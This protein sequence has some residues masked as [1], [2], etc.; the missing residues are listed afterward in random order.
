MGEKLHSLSWEKALVVCS[1]ALILSTWDFVQPAKGHRPILPF[2]QQGRQSVPHGQV[3]TRQK[4]IMGK[5]SGL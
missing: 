5:L 4:I 1:V 2:S 3:L